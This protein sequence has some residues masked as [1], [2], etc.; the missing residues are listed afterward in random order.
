MINRNTKL[1]TV[2]KIVGQPCSPHMTIEEHFK[3]KS[4]C[5]WFVPNTGKAGVLFEG[6]FREYF[7][8]SILEAV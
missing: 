4:K 7:D 6:P 3:N 1:G 2:V 8:Q 5:V